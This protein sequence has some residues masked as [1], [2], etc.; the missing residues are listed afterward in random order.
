MGME[1][2]AYLPIFALEL[3]LVRICAG[4]VCAAT[5]FVSSYVHSPVASGRHFP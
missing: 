4:P 1:G 3:H 2:Q 5:L